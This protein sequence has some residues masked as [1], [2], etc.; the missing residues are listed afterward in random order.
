MP[1]PTGSTESEYQIG[2][3][4]IDLDKIEFY[5]DLPILFKP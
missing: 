3:M 4:V 5:E 2:T 1:T